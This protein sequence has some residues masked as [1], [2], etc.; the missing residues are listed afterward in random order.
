MSSPRAGDELPDVLPTQWGGG[1]KRLRGRPPHAAGDFGDY[2]LPTQ[3]GGGAKRRRGA[4]W[5]GGAKRRRG[6]LNNLS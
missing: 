5:G 3:W 4:Q 6:T 2:V 1:A